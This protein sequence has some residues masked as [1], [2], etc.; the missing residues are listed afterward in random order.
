[1]ARDDAIG[2]LARQ[3]SYADPETLARWGIAPETVSVPG[4][5][6]QFPIGE[7]ARQP[8]LDEQVANYLPPNVRRYWP[9]IQDFVTQTSPP[10]KMLQSAAAVPDVV[11]RAWEQSERL[12]A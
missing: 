9:A 7:L 8:S 6:G 10:L 3:D 12:R 5:G 11:R 4:G 1:M 2:E